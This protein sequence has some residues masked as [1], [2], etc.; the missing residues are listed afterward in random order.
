MPGEWKFSGNT[1][2]SCNDPE[3]DDDDDDE[4]EEEDGDGDA[5]P[6]DDGKH[7]NT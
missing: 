5:V 6:D 3:D 2:N 4:D 7:H 1:E